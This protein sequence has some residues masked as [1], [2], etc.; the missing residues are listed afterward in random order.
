MIAAA[1]AAAPSGKARYTIHIREGTYFE[2]LNIS[3][4]NVAL[5]GDGMG[6]TVITSNRG[7]PKG[8][9]VPSS[10][11]VTARGNGFMAQDLTIQNTA[12]PD[13]NQSLALLTNSQHT[14]LYR[15]G[16]HGFQDTLCAENNLQFYLDCE[17]S[18]TVDFIFG[19]A[20]AVF[21][22]CRLLVRRP[23]INGAHN[24]VTAQ[25]RNKA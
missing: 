4:R 15:C 3:R 16:L 11:T 21:Q 14:V 19:N 13:G 20:K 18:G 10:A 17:I 5:F 12:G 6:K 1:L 2:Q 25:G 7:T 22:S 24:V 23:K 8:G 9:Y